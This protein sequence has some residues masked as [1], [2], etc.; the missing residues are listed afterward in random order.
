MHAIKEAKQHTNGGDLL[1]YLSNFP[2]LDSAFASQNNTV[3]LQMKAGQGKPLSPNAETLFAGLGCYELFF[4]VP[5]DLI[6]SRKLAGGPNRLKHYR[7]VSK[8]DF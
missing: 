3:P 2:V 7:F 5:S 6:M 1:P 4:I 8:E